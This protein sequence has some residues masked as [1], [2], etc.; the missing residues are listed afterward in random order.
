MSYLY[1]ALYANFPI[2]FDASNNFEKK[3]DFFTIFCV[4]LIFFFYLCNENAQLES[5]NKFI[6]EEENTN[7]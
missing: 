5:K 6:Y 1:Y 2:F 4:Q 7:T 3:K